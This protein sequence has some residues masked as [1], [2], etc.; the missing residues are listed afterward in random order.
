MYLAKWNDFD[1]FCAHL[2]LEDGKNKVAVWS[3]VMKTLMSEYL[4][5]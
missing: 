5:V 1:C 3:D 2:T 4:S